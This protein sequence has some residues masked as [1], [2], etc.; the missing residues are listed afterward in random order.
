MIKCIDL[1]LG[2]EGHPILSNLNFEVNKGDY[3]YIIGENGSG[4]TTLMKTILNLV[5]PISGEVVFEDGLSH[6]DVGYL[7][8]QSLIQKDFPA[9]VKEVVLSG[10][11]KNLGNRSFYSKEDYELA[12]QNMERLGISSLAKKSYRSLSGGQ[13]Q[14]VLLARA[15]CATQELCL[16]DEP[17]TGLDPNASK[18]LYEIIDNLNKQGVTIIMI[19]HDLEAAL[20]YASHILSFDTNAF[21]G[22]KEEYLKH[23]NR[24]EINA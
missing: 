18:E 5:A 9:S 21:F 15:L 14:R 2:Y 3:L 22:T 16:L 12:N 7:P 1:T 6:K 20:K 10:C 4:K 24:K 11:L 19:S 23:L 17:V 8:Q 13:Q